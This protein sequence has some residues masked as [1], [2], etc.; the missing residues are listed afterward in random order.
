MSLTRT[1][2]D[3]ELVKRGIESLFRELG[4]VD[5]IRF[6]AMPRTKRIESVKRHR[7]WQ[8]GLEKSA[9]FD[10]IFAES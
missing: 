6:L 7:Q 2:P 9:F 1:V 4:K 10:E 5:A 3:D 8:D